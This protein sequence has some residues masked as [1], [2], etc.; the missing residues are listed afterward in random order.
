M[1][2][3]VLN[4]FSGSLQFAAEIECA[5]DAPTSIKLGLAIKW[6][7]QTRANLTRADLSGANL[8]GANLYGANL[9]GANL[10]RANLTRAD[11]SGADLSGANLSGANL[12][13]ANL[14][15]ANLTRADLYGADLYE[16]DLSGANL[17]GANLY[18]TKNAD[19]A[20]ARTRIL[21]EGEII[22]WKK[23][24]SDVIVKLRI[25][26][27]AARSH[28]FGRKCRAAFAD[29][30]EVHGA[31][32]GVSRHDGRT[33]YRVGERVTPDTFNDNWKEECAEGIHFFI[34]RAEAE[35]Y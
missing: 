2:F 35:A 29:V 9:Y 7:I 17:Y 27:G 6:A 8:S 24:E 31:E 26:A 25:P 28:A 15:R 22:G 34:T 33:R 23:C 10:S 16:A 11:L 4:R 30:L 19:L 32:Y 1:K 21:P 14:S 20:I 18:E 13:G 12:Y 5:D 3:N